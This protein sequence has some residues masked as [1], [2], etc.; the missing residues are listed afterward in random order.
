MPG[1]DHGFAVFSDLDQR[2][3]LDETLV[4]VLSD[5]AAHRS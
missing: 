4:M 2:G 3:M 5:T 1:F